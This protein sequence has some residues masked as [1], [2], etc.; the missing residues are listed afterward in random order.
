MAREQGEYED[1]SHETPWAANKLTLQRTT[2]ICLNSQTYLSKLQNVFVKQSHQLQW[3]A[4][5]RRD[6]KNSSHETPRASAPRL[7][8]G[9]NVFVLIANCICR[10]CKM[11][12]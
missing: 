8:K 4:G 5:G 1:K 3:S 6:Y 2:C 11:Y 7:S 9:E 12:L 10:N